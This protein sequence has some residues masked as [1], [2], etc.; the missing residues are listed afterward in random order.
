MHLRRPLVHP[1]LTQ[2]EPYFQA[3]R[4]NAG[5]SVGY[6]P[7]VFFAAEHAAGRDL[8]HVRGERTDETALPL[9]TIDPEGSRDLDQALHVEARGDGHRVFYAIADVGAHVAPGGVLDLD[10][11]ARGATVY[12]PDIRV[13]LH[14]P[15]M[16][17]GFASLL[18]GQRTKAVLW[19]LDLDG[20]GNL[21]DTD[22][23]RVW[24]KSRRQYTYTELAASPPT[25]ATNLV[26]LLHEVGERRRL[27]AEKRG[28][29][30]LPTPTQE[31]RIDE[32]KLYLDFRAAIG[33]E[34]DNAEISLLTGEAG[35]SLMLA[36]GMGILRTMPPVQ[37][38]ALRR[39]RHQA[40][41]LHI[42]WPEDESY[43]SLLRRLDKTSPATSA[44]FAHATALFRGASWSAFDDAD[45]ALPRPSNL[46]HGAL[47][48]AYAHVTAPLRRL[49]DR[50][51]AEICLAV[52][53]GRNVP[54]WVHQ[55]LPTVGAHMATGDH[56]AK[57]VDRECID[58]VESAVLAPQIGQ[59]FDGVGLDE[60]TVQIAEPAVLARCGGGVK[61]GEDQ[62]V[63]LVRVDYSH[64]P[65][66][67]VVNGE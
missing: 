11:K 29:V 9:I 50:F 43:A 49:V 20:E 56:V 53:A 32:G 37:K 44:F 41:A 65:V 40:R 61:E 34:E 62:H 33:I 64:G 55:A 30:T 63:R 66:F 38:G 52:A 28:A 35:A 2:V 4:D 58:A 22:V 19:T 15:V 39:L 51:G 17:E 24:A 25:E 21:V 36:G 12:C 10:T 26:T 67:E 5:V 8:A 54:E 16:A 13:G 7:A 57:K 6:S 45:P 46:L 31:V 27:V 14:P 42:A 3:I 23:R 60:S 1:P 59:V 18:P 48:V 47:G